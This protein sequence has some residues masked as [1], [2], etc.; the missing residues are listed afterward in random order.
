MTDKL[1][2]PS[3]VFL[4]VGLSEATVHRL[5]RAKKFP[6]PIILGRRRVAYR[7]CEIQAWIDA[8]PRAQ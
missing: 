7:Q 6:V 5:R 2:K 8:Q 1:L 4:M 3:E